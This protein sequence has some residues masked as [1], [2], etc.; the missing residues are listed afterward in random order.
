MKLEFS[1]KHNRKLLCQISSR[2][3]KKTGL[4]VSRLQSAGRDQKYGT[5]SG[6]D[7]VTRGI[8]QVATAHCTVPRLSAHFDVR[9][10]SSANRYN[11]KSGQLLNEKL[12]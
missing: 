2:S 4:E 12:T 5:L 1:D 9:S 8:Y 11:K 10:H 3:E 7:L 6:S